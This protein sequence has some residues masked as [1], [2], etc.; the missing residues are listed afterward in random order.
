MSKQNTHADNNENGDG[1]TSPSSIYETQPPLPQPPPPPTPTTTT[2]TMMMTNSGY[3]L[4]GIGL[5]QP[6][7][8]EELTLAMTKTT[9]NS[10]SESDHS[11]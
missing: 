1:T 10:T 4:D 3:Y 9:I 7:T 5:G 2:S 8:E 6:F 11:C